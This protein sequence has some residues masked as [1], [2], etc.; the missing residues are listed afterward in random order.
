M[1][2]A[3]ELHPERDLAEQLRGKTFGQVTVTSATGSRGSN[4]AWPGEDLY[5]MVLDVKIKP[6]F[7]AC[8]K[9]GK[10]WSLGIK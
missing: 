4:A 10:T 3:D 5:N 6:P 2:D 9:S 8:S 7:P 1:S